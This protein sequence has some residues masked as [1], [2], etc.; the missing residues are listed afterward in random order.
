[1]VSSYPSNLSVNHQGPPQGDLIVEE[2]IT[3]TVRET[4]LVSRLAHLSST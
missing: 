1:M 4:Q 2:E 3:E